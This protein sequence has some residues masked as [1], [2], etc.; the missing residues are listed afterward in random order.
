ME[1]DDCLPPQMSKIAL[2]KAIQKI[3]AMITRLV[4]VDIF[5]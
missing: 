1:K 3:V 5:T 4:D 2:E